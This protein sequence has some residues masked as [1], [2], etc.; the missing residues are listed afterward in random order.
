MPD[1]TIDT[2]TQLLTLNISNI[3]LHVG[4]LLTV[5]KQ[6]AGPSWNDLDPANTI[7]NTLSLLNST[8]TIATF[9]KEGPAVLPT[10]Y[11][12]GGNLDLLDNSGSVL[13]DQNGAPL[14]GF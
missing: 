3:T 7:T 2:S 11:F 8:G 12:Y 14:R 10:D 1:F 4:A 5:I 9:L 13:L 6:Q